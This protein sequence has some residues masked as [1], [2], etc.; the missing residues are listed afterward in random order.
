M[1]CDM[2]YI[3][4]IY[5]AAIPNRQSK[6]AMLLRESYR[7]QGK[8]KTRTLANLSPLPDDALKTLRRSLKGDKLVSANAAFDVIHSRHQGQIE[9]VLRLR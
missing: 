1:V 3:V 9:A 5:I 7:Q 6:P 4:G 2:L 8:V